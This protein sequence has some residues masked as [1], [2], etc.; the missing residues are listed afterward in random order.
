MTLRNS[1]PLAVVAMLLFCLSLEASAGLPSLDP[2][3]KDSVWR[4]TG[5]EI[6]FTD[7]N[8]GVREGLRRIDPTNPDN[9]N[10][11]FADAFGP[12]LVAGA[13][14][15]TIN[16]RNIIWTGSTS[17]G[18]QWLTSLLEPHYGTWIRDARL[19]TNANTLDNLSVMGRNIFYGSYGQTF[20]YDIYIKPSQVEYRSLEIVELV[21]HELQHT[22]QFR[23]CGSSLSNFGW[24]YGYNYARAGL[25][26][27]DNSREVEARNK[28]AEVIANIDSRVNQ[29]FNKVAEYNAS[30]Q[31][32]K[33]VTF[34]P[35]AGWVLIG[36]RGMASWFSL[37]D[38]L[39]KLVREKS[40]KCIAFHPNGGWACFYEGGNTWTNSMP[41]NFKNAM[42]EHNDAK[43]AAFDCQGN[44]LL[45]YGK[46]GWVGAGLDQ[47]IYDRLNQADRE[48]DELRYFCLDNSGT[49]FLRT[50]KGASWYI[51]KDL[52]DRMNSLMSSGKT[53][54]MV[55][56]SPVGD[57][58]VVYGSNGYTFWNN[59][60]VD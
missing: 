48:G 23:Q 35:D 29:C 28:A 9:Y 51:R 58:L 59:R 25:K 60:L 2:F 32:I 5:R 26:Y 20:G 8:S 1:R 43:F 52:S 56:L 30:K 46:N 53:P 57:W 15:M 36:D 54:E 49:Y 10:K 16:N 40:I 37:P 19:R 3:N 27:A 12:A 55:T 42:K 7:K 18:N 6:D 21:A 22:V 38:D 39:E 44:W 50:D 11:L 33:Y 31:A 14:W 34:K 45:L 41:E 17:L 47:R 24:H 4:R 13:Q